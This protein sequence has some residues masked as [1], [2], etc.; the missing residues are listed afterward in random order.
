MSKSAITNGK[1]GSIS[2]HVTLRRL[3]GSSDGW[4]S[5]PEP[6]DEERRDI[7][8]SLLA[9]RGLIGAIPPDDR[10][11]EDLGEIVLATC[12]GVHLHIHCD[13]VRTCFCGSKF[14]ASGRSNQLYCSTKCRVN[15]YQSTEE[16][17]AE[18]RGADRRH[19]EYRKKKREG[20][21][22]ALDLI[23]HREWVKKTRP[24]EIQ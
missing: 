1:I 2:D 24:R 3:E 5:D 20:T 18:R 16:F 14:M 17:K 12:N 15:R 6:L 23:E 9:W 21:V 19:Y 11:F 4:T 10:V 7:T 13:R 8:I 22:T